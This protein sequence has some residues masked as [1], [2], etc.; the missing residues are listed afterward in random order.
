M[1]NQLN[2]NLVRE[3][4]RTGTLTPTDLHRLDAWAEGPPS[5]G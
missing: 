2:D 5:A 4:I 3:L 1:G